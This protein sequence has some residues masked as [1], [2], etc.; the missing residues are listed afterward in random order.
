MYNFLPP[1]NSIIPKKLRKVSK[2]LYQGIFYTSWFVMVE[3]WKHLNIH[4]RRM[5]KYTVVKATQW[6]AIKQQYK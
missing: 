1:R 4:D 3:N 6:I 2:E 5:D